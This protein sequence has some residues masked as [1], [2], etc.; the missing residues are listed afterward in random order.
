MQDAFAL[1]RK[2]GFKITPRRRAMV[3][4][5]HE[6]LR[7]LSPLEVQAALR[8]KLGRCGLPGVYRNLEVLV[9]CGI[10]FRVADFRRQRRYALC[11]SLHESHHHH[12]ICISCGQTGRIEECRYPSGVMVGGFRVLSHIAQFEGLCPSCLSE[13]APEPSSS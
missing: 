4:L 3:A 5:F 6:S 7:P 10:L 11:A 1:V 12:I 8:K 13:T 2:A 9:E